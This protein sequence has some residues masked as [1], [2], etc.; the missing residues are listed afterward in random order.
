M[1]Q[2]R[3][4]LRMPG[5]L[6]LHV[7]HPMCRVNSDGKSF[8][9]KTGDTSKEGMTVPQQQILPPGTRRDHYHCGICPNGCDLYDNIRAGTAKVIHQHSC[10]RFPSIMTNFE[11]VEEKFV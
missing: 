5:L 9:S 3:N 8:E 7:A 6:E 11:F 4:V 10:H 2:G 1:L